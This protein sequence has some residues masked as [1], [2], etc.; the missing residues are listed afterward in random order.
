MVDTSVV[1]CGETLANPII[2]AS[3]TFGYGREFARFYD[4]NCLGSFALKGTTE[5]ARFGNAPHSRRPLR[6][7]QLRGTAEP[8]RGRRYRRGIAQYPPHLCR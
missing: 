1:L 5:A 3:G 4:L 7:P 6:R 8:G 2:P